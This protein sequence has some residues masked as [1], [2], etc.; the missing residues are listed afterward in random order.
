MLFESF[1]DRFGII[2]RNEEVIRFYPAWL[3]H[4]RSRRLLLSLSR[5]TDT[6]ISGHRLARAEK[7]LGYDDPLAYEDAIR[8]Y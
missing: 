7:L 2:E 3:R 4:C 1:K 5:S 6:I 8:L